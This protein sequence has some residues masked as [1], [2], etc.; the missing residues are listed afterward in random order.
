MVELRG[1]Q[2]RQLHHRH[3]HVRSLVAQLGA[4]RFEHPLL[5]V[6]GAAVGRLQ[7]DAAVGERRADEHERA[8]VARQ[9]ARER[10]LRPPH[11]SQVG[12]L[13]RPLELLRLD[14]LEKREHRRHRVVH[15]HVDRPERV[16]GRARRSV[17][18]L[19]VR[20]VSR[21]HER[22]AA[23]LLD[24]AARALEPVAPARDEADAHARCGET[25]ND[26]AADAARRAR[27]DDG[28]VTRH[29]ERVPGGGGGLHESGQTLNAIGSASRP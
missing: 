27:H 6:L 23:R 19:E 24:L 1:V 14:V 25:A 13:G 4:Q 12:D 21:Q 22:L 8:A 28:L 29:A 26:R 5:R 7:R 3:L 17:D 18:G 16:L 10:S 20:H 2:A 11:R 9:H 15:P